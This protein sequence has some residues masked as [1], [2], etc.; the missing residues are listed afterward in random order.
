MNTTNTTTKAEIEAMVH[1]LSDFVDSYGDGE[2]KGGWA[3]GHVSAYGGVGPEGI[4]MDDPFVPASPTTEYSDELGWHWQL[5]DRDD[6]VTGA[7]TTGLEEA[8]EEHLDRIAEANKRSFDRGIL[9]VHVAIIEDV[10][11]VTWRGT[12]EYDSWPPGGGGPPDI[13]FGENFYYND[14]GE[15]PFCVNARDKVVPTTVE[16]LHKEEVG[17]DLEPGGYFVE[18]IESEAEFVERVVEPALD[19]AIERREKTLESEIPSIDLYRTEGPP[20]LVVGA[21]DSVSRVEVVL[22]REL[23]PAMEVEEMAWSATV[24]DSF[25]AGDVESLTDDL[26][27]WIDRALDSVKRDEDDADEEA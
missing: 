26:V 7:D 13:L 15:P 14:A 24:E 18:Y 12:V 25:G 5:E 2:P 10:A 6:V 16:A 17:A 19:A 8:Y 20:M 1:D 21:D 4:Y 3:F 22:E 23:D 9:E 27:A 11:R